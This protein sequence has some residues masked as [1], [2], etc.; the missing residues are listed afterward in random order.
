MFKK[1]CTLLLVSLLSLTITNASALSFDEIASSPQ[2]ANTLKQEVSKYLGGNKVLGNI[3]INAQLNTVAI[4]YVTEENN[5]L[6][7]TLDLPNNSWSKPLWDQNTKISANSNLW[8]S[9]E[10]NWAILPQIIQEAR[11]HSFPVNN[12]IY[13]PTL[14]N[15]LLTKDSI[16]VQLTSP[17]FTTQSFYYITDWDGNFLR[18]FLEPVD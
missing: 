3:W 11:N 2:A 9:T 5:V 17:E 14:S 1:C 18:A 7:S 4:S 10:R 8:D 15:I 12:E 16:K 13:R 6:K